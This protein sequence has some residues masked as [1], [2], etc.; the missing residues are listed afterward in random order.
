MIELLE[1][2]ISQAQNELKSIRDIVRF[3]V[4]L[5]N[6]HELYYGHG[7]TN[8]YDEV[9]YLTLYTLNL[10]IDIDLEIIFNALLL[11][12]EISNILEN[13]TQR[14]KFAKPVPYIINQAIIQGYS[15]YIDER[16][17]IPRSFIPEILL[18][19]ILSPWLQSINVANV[20]D[21]CTGNG[22]IAIIS[23]EYFPQTQI[24]AADIDANALE[25]AKINIKDYGLENNITLVV[26]DLFKNIPEIKFDIIFSNPPYVDKDGMARLTT[27]YKHEPQHAL[28]GGEDGL[29]FVKQIVNNAIN[30]LSSDG[31]LVVE[32]GDNKKILEY[33]YPKMPF[34]WLETASDQGFVFLLTHK[35]LNDYFK[36]H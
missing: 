35:Q 36:C 7:T 18:N 19:N 3:G 29:K 25:V 14:V 32:I 28:Y 12:S 5:F 34:T 21:L 31:I 33:N 20:L 8:C 10:P 9:V 15:F 2:R 26:S 6:K 22:S 24:L 16:A 1:Q 4:S 27:E 11:K 17:I 30:Y 23:S 13:F